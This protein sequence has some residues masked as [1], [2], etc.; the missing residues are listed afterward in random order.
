MTLL[1]RLV[2][3]GKL[4]EADVPRAEVAAANA[5]DR[6]LHELI[7]EQGY[8]KEDDV[9]AVLAEEFGLEVVDLTKTTVEPETLQSMPLRL[10]HRRNLMPIARENG[11]LVVATGNPYDVYALDELQSVT[12]LHVQPV[13][14]SPREITRLIRTHFGVGG[15][16][17]ASMAAEKKKTSSFL[18]T[19]KPTTP[20]WPSRRRRRRSS[21]WST[22]FSS[23]RPTN[24][25]A[26]FTSS[27]RKRRSEFATALTASCKRRNCRRRSPDSRTRSSAAL[28][29]WPG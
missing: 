14:A 12:G 17:V 4:R 13:L 20:S 11:T 18:R 25:P 6:P 3:S 27:P 1:Q 10:M 5:P 22:R 29:S 8:A 15:D 19:S 23:R 7:V 2:Q 24:G 28:R 21:N 16:T 9:L 26:I